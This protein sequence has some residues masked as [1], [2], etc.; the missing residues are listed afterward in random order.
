[1]LCPTGA[2]P[3]PLVPGSVPEAPSYQWADALDGLCDALAARGLPCDLPADAERVP[4]LDFHA[5]LPP[6]DPAQCAARP[7]I[8]LDLDHAGD[9][10]YHFVYDLERLA[11]A[12]PE[13]D[14]ACT[15]RVEFPT[16][17]FRDVSRA[18]AVERSKWSEACV[19]L[20]G[21]TPW[22]FHLTLTERNRFKPKALCGVDARVHA[23]LWDYPGNPLELLAGMD[24]L[25]DFLIANVAQVP[26]R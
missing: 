7:T 23:P 14:F 22:P 11:L 2:I 10:A 9:D 16:R 12:L 15:R 21:T 19:A 6:P 4:M 17:Q 3:L 13:C 5:A 18:A 1:V 24:D 20:V 25:V 26:D 8:W